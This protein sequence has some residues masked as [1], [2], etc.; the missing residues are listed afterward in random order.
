MNS[1]IILGI[2]VDFGMSINEALEVIENKLLKDEKNHYICTTNPE[3]VMDAQCDKDF[4]KIINESDLSLPD[5]SGLVYANKYIEGIKKF[6]KDFVFPI[7]AF[8]YGLHIGISSSFKRFRRYEDSYEKD[9]GKITGVELT[10]KIC[11]TASRKGYSVFFLGGRPKN[12]LGKHINNSDKD[13][14]ETSATEMQRL[15]PGLNIVGATSKFNKMRSDDQKTLDYIKRCMNEKDVDHIDFLF[16]AYGHPYQEKWIVRNKDNIPVK[17][18]VGV[19][20]T[21]DYIIGQCELPPE[22]Y[23]KKNLGWLYRLLKQPW[24]AKRILK[25]FPTF[26]VKVF[27]N[28]IQK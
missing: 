28:S 14:A 19:G 20:G 4:A 2:R 5:G 26:P 18:S 3:F 25:A 6:K 12:A 8:A 13:T 23:V 10:Y 1:R 22:I 27:L 9:G 15:Y 24:R 16:V 7:K 17:V 21:F 11:E